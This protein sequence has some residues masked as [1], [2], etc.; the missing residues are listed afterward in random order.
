MV[1]CDK[2]LGVRYGD[3][4]GKILGVSCGDGAGGRVLSVSYGHG[5]GAGRVLSV[6]CRGRGYMI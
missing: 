1:G 5:H 3:G 6:S 2:V 4:V